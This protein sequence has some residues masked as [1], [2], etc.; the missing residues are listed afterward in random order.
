MTV[1]NR[2]AISLDLIRSE[3][4]VFSVSN[5]RFGWGVKSVGVRPMLGEW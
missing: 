2:L 3:G 5:L 1:V 4:C